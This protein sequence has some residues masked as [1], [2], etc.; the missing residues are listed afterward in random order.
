MPSKPLKK[1]SATNIMKFDLKSFK[2]DLSDI[3]ES[4]TS[5]STSTSLNFT[6]T[7]MDA[8]PT[9]TPLTE[10]PT[11]E[12]KPLDSSACSPNSIKTL[13]VSYNFKSKDELNSSAIEPWLK[14]LNQRSTT[15]TPRSSKIP[16]KSSTFPYHLH[17]GRVN[18][19]H[20]ESGLLLT[21]RDPDNKKTSAI[22]SRSCEVSMTS[23]G[24]FLRPRPNRKGKAPKSKRTS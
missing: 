16:I 5:S 14:S 9:G 8:S 20:S 11:I 6:E 18:D 21:N 1:R 3:P 15:K 22:D 2:P 4:P 7:M 13:F 10:S 19:N 24:R 23:T 17:R 12:K